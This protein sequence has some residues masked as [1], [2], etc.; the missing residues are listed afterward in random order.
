MAI[1][2]LRFLLALTLALSAGALFGYDSTPLPVAR[3]DDRPDIEPP[4][5]WIYV[6]DEDLATLPAGLDY[7]ES[8][9]RADLDLAFPPAA[10]GT[11]PFKW[12]I[13]SSNLF[14][15][16][17]TDPYLYDKLWF[18]IIEQRYGLYVLERTSGEVAEALDLLIPRTDG[19]NLPDGQSIFAGSG[20]IR[21]PTVLGPNFGGGDGDSAYAVEDTYFVNNVGGSP[22]L[23][24]DFSLVPYAA[25]R[26]SAVVA[27]TLPA[28][29]IVP[30]GTQTRFIGCKEDGYVFQYWPGGSD[31]AVDPPWM[32]PWA[33]VVVRTCAYAVAEVSAGGEPCI[34]AGH[35]AH[36]SSTTDDP[37]IWATQHVIEERGTGSSSRPVRLGA[38][39]RTVVLYECHVEDPESF[40][41]LKRHEERFQ[42][43]APDMLLVAIP[44]SDV[45]E[46]EDVPI[47]VTLEVGKGPVSGSVKWS[48]VKNERVQLLQDHAY[49]LVADWEAVFKYASVSGWYGEPC[50]VFGPTWPQCSPPIL[51]RSLTGFRA[52]PGANWRTETAELQLARTHARIWT[53]ARKSILCV[54]ANLNQCISAIERGPHTFT[55]PPTGRI[56]GGTL[57]ICPPSVPPVEP[58]PGNG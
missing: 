5:V 7:N 22:D 4:L 35:P 40:G 34:P 50:S 58:T 55:A 57:P 54:P 32:C 31:T 15:Q 52:F 23:T 3:A 48:F 38:T 20:I 44:N 12:L 29:P 53:H 39:G 9:D 33:E 42:I 14:D 49:S 43:E 6:L 11:E 51:N 16:L 17:G 1:R 10:G 36:P 27:E 41:G 28:P 30:I 46:D 2:P 24:S 45:T 26:L 25:A 19:S 47:D 37:Y 13:I 21:F 8:V 56:G 18:T